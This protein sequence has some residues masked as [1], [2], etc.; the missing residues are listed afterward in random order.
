MYINMY[1][2][3]N[4]SHFLCIINLLIITVTFFYRPFPISSLGFAFNLSCILNNP[5][6]L[7]GFRPQSHI[8]SFTGWEESDFLSNFLANTSDPRLE[9]RGSYKEVSSYR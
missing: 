1:I 9:C 2:N 8:K 4:Y 6:A 7:F 5:K 3:N